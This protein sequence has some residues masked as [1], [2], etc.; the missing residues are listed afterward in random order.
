MVG[1]M[2]QMIFAARYFPNFKCEQNLKNLKQVSI[3]TLKM[4][5]SDNKP[6]FLPTALYAN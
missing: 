2:S 3:I 4:I 1:D 6:L 5:N